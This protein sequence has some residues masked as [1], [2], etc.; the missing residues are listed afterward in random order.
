MTGLSRL[1]VAA[2]VAV[3]ALATAAPSYAAP[4]TPELNRAN[5][6]ALGFWDE[7]PTDCTSID[8]EIVP[9]AALSDDGEGFASIPSEPQPCVLWLARR[10]AAPRLAGRACAILIHEEGHL[11]GYEHSDD[12]HNVMYPDVVGGFIPA[13]CTRFE[14]R[15]LNRRERE[16]EKSGPRCPAHPG[17]CGSDFRSD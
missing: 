6:V 4:F 3:V 17:R 12:P 15:E 7:T 16:R 8:R 14:L 11:L 1:S 13:V 10:L 9:N 5:Q 2:G